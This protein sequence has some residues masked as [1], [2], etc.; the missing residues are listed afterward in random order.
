MMPMPR[1]LSWIEQR[2]S[3]PK[4]AGS[5]PARGTKCE[6]IIMK[7]GNLEFTKIQPNDSSVAAPVLAAAYDF[8]IEDD[9]FTATIDPSLADT[10][11][12]CSAYEINE[13]SSVNCIVVESKRA[14]ETSYAA[15]LVM[16]NTFADINGAV[17]KEL[18]A[19]KVSFAS[20]DLAIE[21]TAMEYGG[22]TPVGL[23]SGWTILVDTEVMN[24]EAVVIGSG[25]RS[26]KILIK[27]DALKKLPGASVLSIKK[28]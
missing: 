24:S 5:S 9:I 16:A 7:L 14:G 22:V 21:L 26:S 4:V 11:E 25:L 19:R 13:S 2:T 28:S 23:P 27:T 6:F 3:K 20:Q 18:G 10:A 12:F 17:R 1:Q 8:G 15:V